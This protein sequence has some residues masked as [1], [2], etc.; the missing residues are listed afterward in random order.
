MRS[1]VAWVV[2]IV[3]CTAWAA[4]AEPAPEE[5][6]TPAEPDAAEPDTAAPAP[7]KPVPDSPPREAPAPTESDSEAAP[8]L[9]AR[10][11]VSTD[12]DAKGDARAS[13]G[14]TKR[15]R[16]RQ[17]PWIRRWRPQ[18]NTGEI[19]IFAGV[20]IPAERHDLYDPA[21]RPSEPYWQAGADVGV[22]AGYYP[23]APLGIEVEFNA[24]PTRMRTVTNDIA[25]M[26]GFQSHVV[27]QLPFY[28]I[29]PFFLAGGGL[30]GVRSS[31]VTN[32]NDVDPALHYG[33]GIKFFLHEYVGLR[34]EARNIVSAREGLENSGA[35]NVQVLGGLMVTLGRKPP[36]APPPPP[37]YVDPDRDK[38]GILNK[39]DDCP[40]VAGVA[41]HGC[42]DTDGDTFRDSEDKCP[43]V[44]G[45]APDGCPVKDTDK[46]G[47]L[48][49]DDDC[50]FEP[51]TKNDYK[52][53]D[54][55]PDEVPPPIKKFT[56]NIPGIVFDFNKA[57]I[58]PSS[59]PVLDEAVAVLKEFEDVRINIVGHTDDVGTPAFNEDLSKR[60]AEAVKKYLVDN[61]IDASRITTEGRGATDPD[62]PNDTEANRAKNRRIEFEI[63]SREPD[64]STGTPAPADAPKK[65]DDKPPA[66]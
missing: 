8:K 33:G 14:Q 6:A 61:G 38:D 15:E 22:R 34:V 13:R 52:D 32:G 3:P 64:A 12:G 50:P 59:K 42:P 43:E 20:F 1:L 21:T 45:V 51:E 19:G 53:H 36:K 5:T 57:T 11:K 46:D 56:G 10:G 62:A 28:N 54:G 60:R 66:E 49:P 65:P 24:M 35:A 41:P 27:L 29:A 31:P 58:K 4:G 25:V 23:L 18:R 40:D 17:D 44:P 9:E 16:Y 55:C 63:L 2:G 39:S 47:F 48:D 26:Y 37:P 30:L 7:A